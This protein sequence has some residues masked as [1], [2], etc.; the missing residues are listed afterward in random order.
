MPKCKN[1]YHTCLKT[2]PRM[3]CNQFWTCYNEITG[4]KSERLKTGV[5]LKYGGNKNGN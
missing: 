1:C 5:E 3:R 2:P 4:L